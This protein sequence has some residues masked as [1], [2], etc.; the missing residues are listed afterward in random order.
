[1]RWLVRFLA[2]ATVFAVPSWL[3]GDAYHHGLAKA[4]LWMLRI[5]S[6][7]LAFQ[8]PDI[9]ASHILGVYAA[10]CLAST[11]APLARRLVALA[12]GLVGMV[13]VE[14]LAG[15]L[16][17]RW[18]LDAGAGGA[19]SPPAMRLQSYLTSLP[20]WIGAPVLW[21]LLLGGWELPRTARPR[22]GGSRPAAEA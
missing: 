14:L 2:W 20:A 11:R 21:L 13:A 9:P 3:I 6:D 17:V 22:R 19:V 16:A 5:P 12:I 8:P 15:A 4:T 1:M 18:S 10:L 7:R